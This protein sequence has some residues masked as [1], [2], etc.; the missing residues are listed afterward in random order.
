MV[1][2]MRVSSTETHA[3]RR[4]IKSVALNEDRKKVVASRSIKASI[5]V[6]TL[7][8]STLLRKALFSFCRQNFPGDQCEI[9]VV[10]NGSKD[11]TRDVVY[12]LSK[13]H[14]HHQI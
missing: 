12:S 6:P 5:I 7:N 14:P 10:D 8:R 13:N 4:L 11:N 3:H 9:I 1:I 2:P